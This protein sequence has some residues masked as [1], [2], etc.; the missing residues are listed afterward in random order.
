MQRLNQPDRVSVDSFMD[1]TTQTN[2]QYNT[3]VNHAPNTALVGAKEVQLLRATIPYIQPSIPNYQTVLYYYKT[4]SAN[5]IP[6]ANDLHA[7]RLYPS[8]YIPPSGFTD[9]TLNGVYP[10]P[11]QFVATLNAAAAT[12]GDDNTLNTLWEADDVVF[13]FDA[14]INKITMT[15]TDNSSYYSLAG[16]NDPL[17]QASQASNDIEIANFDT[18]TSRQPYLLGYTLNLRCGFACDGVNIPLGSGTNLVSVKC[19]NLTGTSFAG[20]LPIVADSYPD[21]NYTGNVYVYS[22]IVAN[23]GYGSVNKKNLLGVIPVDVPLGG[24]IQY[25]GHSADAKAKKVASEVYSIDIELRDDASQ[26]FLLPDSAN[27][28]MELGFYYSS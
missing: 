10:S 5:D 1:T 14:T 18:T 12:G 11:T 24:L 3:F 23:S 25:L 6:V 27:V 7:I 15:G 19:A 21:L 26:P 20:G 4:A 9:F 22:N 2:G 28:N 13:A 8:T 17:V 16:Y